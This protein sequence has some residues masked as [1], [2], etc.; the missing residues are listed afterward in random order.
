MNVDLIPEMLLWPNV[1][2]VGPLPAALQN[3]LRFAAGVGS[4]ARERGA[5]KALIEF[6]T[7]P[8]AIR[9]IKAK[10]MQPG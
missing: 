1:E 8:A 2:I 9:V 4:R 5:S 3:D 7:A 6:L 10:G